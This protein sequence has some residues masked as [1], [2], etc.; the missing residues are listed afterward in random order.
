MKADRV[1]PS[2]KIRAAKL[3]DTESIASVLYESFAEF[4]SIYT[5]EDFAATAPAS[6]QI[7]ARWT[8]GPVWVVVSAFYNGKETDQ[9]RFKN[10]K[11][12]RLDLWLY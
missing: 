8:E 9:V 11:S 7:R 4:E 6:E 12:S 5:P 3:E 2:I 10:D 1:I